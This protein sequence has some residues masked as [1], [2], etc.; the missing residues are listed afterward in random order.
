MDKPIGNKG[1]SIL[2]TCISWPLS[3]SASSEMR[4]HAWW[5]EG[6]AKDHPLPLLTVH[7]LYSTHREA[8][9][10]P[11]EQQPLLCKTNPKP[12][13]SPAF[14]TDGNDEW[15]CLWSYSGKWH[16][17]RGSW[18]APALR[19]C[20]FHQGHF[21]QVFLCKFGIAEIKMKAQLH[22]LH[23]WSLLKSW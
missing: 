19:P 7:P 21:A 17:L 12:W 2:W 18:R 1:W 20:A 9:T 16:L 13:Q 15:R 8:W 11:Q 23:L 5:G 6:Q 14:F 22:F 10:D 3:C 4:V